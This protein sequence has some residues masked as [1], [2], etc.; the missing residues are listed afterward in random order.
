MPSEGDRSF[1]R[2]DPARRRVRG[3]DFVGRALR[4]ISENPDDPT[5]K[6]MMILLDHI[7][8]ELPR[9]RPLHDD[10]IIRLILLV[11][12]AFL[13]AAKTPSQKYHR[14]HGLARFLVFVLGPRV[15]AQDDEYLSERFDSLSEQLH[16]LEGI[17][18][19]YGPANPRM[20]ALFEGFMELASCLGLSQS[21]EY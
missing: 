9:N 8:E 12:S 3:D 21:P 11:A 10:E 5:L 1:L 17:S 13:D 19:E 6:E 4:F 15:E 20:I 14:I 16:D 2:S 18:I 7:E